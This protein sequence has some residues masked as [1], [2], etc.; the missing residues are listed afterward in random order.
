MQKNEKRKPLFSV[1]AA[2]CDIDTFCTG[3]PGGQ[4]QNKKAT[5]VRF[6]HRASGAVGESRTFRSQHQNK[7]AA[8]ERMGKSKTFQAWAKIEAAKRKGVKS[9]EQRVEEG[10]APHN[11]K[12]EV[13]DGNSRW[14]E[15][16]PEELTGDES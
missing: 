1:T 2:D 4:A 9:T 16:K 7:M 11:I 5:G 8:W 13:L 3:G 12:T 6:T 15:R 14:Q 10:M